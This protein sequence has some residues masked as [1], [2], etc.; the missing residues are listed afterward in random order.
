MILTY[1][2]SSEMAEA[3]RRDLDVPRAQAAEL[4]RTAVE[5]VERGFYTNG[6]GEQVDWSRAVQAAISPRASIPPEAELPSIDSHFF[7]KTIV[8]SLMKPLE[9]VLCRS[10]ALYHTLRGDE[11]YE[12]HRKRERPD[13]TDWAIYSSNIPVFPIARRKNISSNYLL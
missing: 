13:S 8:Q 7:Q 2:D 10:S 11:M 1:L 4:G 6:R 9:E 3:R 12:Y 5:A